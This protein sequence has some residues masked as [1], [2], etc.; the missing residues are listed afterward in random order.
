ML[1]YTVSVFDCARLCMKASLG[2]LLTGFQ[3]VVTGNVHQGAAVL[4][5]PPV[6]WAVGPLEKAVF[7]GCRLEWNVPGLGSFDFF[8]LLLHSPK[9]QDLPELCS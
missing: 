2:Y 8:P 1:G 6:S 7:R 5:A 3:V 9:S 4:H